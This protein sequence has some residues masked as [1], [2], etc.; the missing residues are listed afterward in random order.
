M[1]DPKVVVNL[2]L[3]LG[4]GVDLGRHDNWVKDSSVPR[5]ERPSEGTPKGGTHVLATCVTPGQLDDCVALALQQHG[6]Q[7]ALRKRKG[8]GEFSH[9]VVAFCSSCPKMDNFR[10]DSVHSCGK[11]RRH[12]A[13]GGHTPR[14]RVLLRGRH[15]I[16]FNPASSDSVRS[17]RQS[18]VKPPLQSG[19]C[20]EVTGK[21][22]LIRK[23]NRLDLS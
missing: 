5:T 23:L 19:N 21:D 1:L 8:R 17:G 20:R 22:S 4:V 11:S 16:Q 2:L 9:N 18:G 3:E 7:S 15:P 14:T 6:Q 12:F 10:R 13:R